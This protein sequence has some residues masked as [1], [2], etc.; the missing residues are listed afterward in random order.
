MSKPQSSVPV[1]LGLMAFL[2]LLI[3]T[4]AS[5]ND[6]LKPFLQRLFG[7]SYG[8]S[9]W[10]HFAFY[11]TYLFMAIPTSMMAGRLG[12]RKSLLVGLS[13]MVLG[14]L[15]GLYAGYIG[16]YLFFVLAVFGLAIGVAI[17]GVLVNPYV[18]Q[19]G[20]EENNNSRLNLVNAFYSMGGIVGPLLGSYL[21]Y[22]GYDGQNL[23]TQLSYPV[24]FCLIGVLLI[25]IL[26][27][28]LVKIPEIP[29]SNEPIS[30]EGFRA[31]IGA[32]RNLRWGML[33]MLIYLGVE[34][35]TGSMIAKF[36]MQ[37]HIWG[38]SEE[39]AGKW[40]A[41]YWGSFMVGRLIAARLGN[42]ISAAQFLRINVFSGMGMVLLVI[43]GKGAFAGVA[44]LGMGLANSVMFSSIYAMGVAGL[45][46]RVQEAS[47]FIFML[48]GGGALI[49]FVQNMLADIPKVGI[50]GSFFLI[51]ICYLYIL[52]YSVNGY[53][54]TEG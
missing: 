39:A 29:I 52:W 7:L 40:V 19:V 20:P 28:I 21:L 33:A 3:G 9:S 35:G 47:S 2:F 4:L 37:D 43:F 34:V 18:S 14:G 48:V 17:I 30:L 53:K 15:I 10:I 22:L 45:G 11:I 24:Y 49:T 44:I 51:L 5:F 41:V 23:S 25:G 46:N 32:H 16:Q 8:Q 36:L 31:L 6:V 54:P 38:I 1:A 26:A 12:Y 50:N 13:V 27:F 42:R